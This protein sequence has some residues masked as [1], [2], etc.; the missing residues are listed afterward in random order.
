M[1]ALDRGD[2][3]VVVLARE[4]LATSRN[5]DLATATDRDLCRDIGRL[6][7]SVE[8]LLLVIDKLTGR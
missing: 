2:E 1:S 7:Y 5:M 6:A 8:S 3:G 4:A